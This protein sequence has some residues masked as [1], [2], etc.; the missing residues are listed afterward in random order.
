[1]TAADTVRQAQSF[2]GLTPASYRV[3]LIYP[4]LKFSAGPNR[5]PS[6]ADMDC[7]ASAPAK[8]TRQPPPPARAPSWR[9][10]RKTKR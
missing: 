1:M 6:Y 9:Q 3:I 4:P 10:C 2:V 5:K 7:A 8:S